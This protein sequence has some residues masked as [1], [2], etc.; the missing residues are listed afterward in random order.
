LSRHTIT[1]R[2]LPSAAIS[3]RQ[4]ARASRLA[5]GWYVGQPTASDPV[6]IP[7]PRPAMIAAALSVLALLQAAPVGRPDADTRAWW[8][9]TS[10]LSADSMQG[11]DAGSPGHE[12]AARHVVR[13]LA[14]AGVKPLG[15]AGTWY[16][17]IPMDEVAVTGGR[18]TVGARA[19]RFLHD[20]TL[21]AQAAP[22]TV[23]GP[24]AYRGYCGA[25]VLG[26]VR[27]KLVICH[28]ARRAGLPTDEQRRT[29]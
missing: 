26:D 3:A 16:Q 4:L 18:I 20:V 23:A 14:A 9:R 21:R 25:D 28:A 1:R 12:R 10:V 5:R 2:I 17:W 8:Q 27:G 11:R 22:A 6:P 13:W 29:A 24:L 19:L 15:D 7:L